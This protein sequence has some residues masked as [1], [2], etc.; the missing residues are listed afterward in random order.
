M[1]VA[2]VGLGVIGTVHLG[3]LPTLPDVSV[4][5]VV[6]P[7]PHVAGPLDVERF[8]SLADA[9][10][11]GRRPDLVVL[12]TPTDTH[13]D[14]AAEALAG[15]DGLVLSEKP[16]TRDAAR[17]R[18]LESEQRAH[19][20]RLRVVNHFAFSPEVEWA[21]ETVHRHGWGP[22]Q[23]VV[24]SFADPYG[25]KTPAQR[26]SYV[27]PWVDSG[28]NQL[29]LLSRLC[30]GWVVRDHEV[31]PS[32]LRSVT[33]LDFDGGRATLTATWATGA[34]SKQTWLRWSDGVEVQLDH[35]AMTGAVLEDGT[36]TEHL[37]HDGTVERKTAHYTA[38]YRALLA[39]TDE[40]LLGL[41]L[42]REVAELLDAADAAARR[43]GDVRWTVR[44]LG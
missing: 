35:T 17:L 8:R 26:T 3:V 16:L 7:R 15:S 33:R 25:L 11:V 39:G 34:S 31:H 12:A 1:D 2:V 32:G 28:S 10:A 5:F 30:R 42:A 6:D 27:S 38:M 4:A 13:L 14:L 20:G 23:Q 9:L 41:A 18:Q 44:R 24:A 22:P 19:L 40:D 21:V 36:V 37:G 43:P 29:S